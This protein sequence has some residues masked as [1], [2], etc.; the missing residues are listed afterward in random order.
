MQYRREI[1]GL[2]ALAVVPVMLFHAGFTAFGGGYVGVDVF[3]VISGYLITSII[4]AELEQER[5]SMIRFW[6][7]RARRIL[8]ALFVVM[9]VTIVL[10][11]LWM[12]PEEMLRLSKALIAVS[13]FGSNVWFWMSSGYFD[14]QAELNALLHTWSLSVEEQYYLLFPLLLTFIWPWGRKARVSCL[15][16]IALLSLGLSV[17]AT[18]NKPVAAFYLLPSRAWELLAGALIALY[19]Q[20]PQR[21]ALPVW[22]RQSGSALGILLISASVLIFDKHS[23]WPGVYALL[24]VCGTLLVIVLADVS[25]WAGRLL[26]SRPLVAVGLISYSAYLWHQPLLALTRHRSLHEPSLVLMTGVLL[27]SLLLAW[28]SWRWVERPFRESGRFSRRQIFTMA[29][30]GSLLIAAIGAW[31]VKSKGHESRAPAAMNSI[32]MTFPQID[33]GWCFYSVDSIF[34]LSVGKLGLDCWLGDRKSARKLLLFGD[35]YAASYEPLW[36]QVA[37]DKNLAVHVVNTNWCHPSLGKEYA[38]PASSRANAQCQINREYLNARLAD[39]DM[40]VI[41]GAWGSI[42]KG[43]HL[44]GVMRWL[45]ASAPS[46][47]K[48]LIMPTPHQYDVNIMHQ[49]RKSLFLSQPFDVRDV[50]SRLDDEARAANERLD[51]WAK[52]RANVQFLQRDW[53]FQLNGV[54]SQVDAQGRPFSLDGGHLTVTAAETAAS[55]FIKSPSYQ[56]VP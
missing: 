55:H 5:F 31:G 42:I 14:S 21:Q 47:R 56:F 17:W 4:A 53:L 9:L 39:Y 15:F 46:V 32:D 45:D 7:R 37:K 44:Q 11:Y 43:E 16:L 23:P 33:N 35:S 3:F 40:V 48:L 41:A 6:E 26:A 12:L 30:C 2:R 38:G 1:D 34:T 24:P 28:M 51:A 52:G 13:V 22:L 8:P 25:T 50:G 36:K 49:Y 20:N 54:A 27:S 29:L 18:A 10:A 19:L